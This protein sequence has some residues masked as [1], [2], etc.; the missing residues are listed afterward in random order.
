MTSV[1]MLSFL[2]FLLLFLAFLLMS[3]SWSVAI[4]DNSNMVPSD[5][6]PVMS[7]DVMNGDIVGV[8]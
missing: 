8:A 4:C 5:S 1:G 6:L 2:V 3:G 7:F